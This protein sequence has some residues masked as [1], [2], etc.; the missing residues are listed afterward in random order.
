LSLR[1]RSLADDRINT[2]K[3]ERVTAVKEVKMKGAASKIL[4][5][6]GIMLILAAILWWA[7]AVNSLVKLPDDVELGFQ[8]EGEIT[9]YQ[10]SLTQERFPEGEEKKASLQTEMAC[11]ANASEFSSSTGVLEAV[12]TTRIEGMPEKRME[13]AYVLDRKTVENIKDDR[14]YAY[15]Y[16]DDEGNK[17]EGTVVNREDNYYPLLPLDTSKDQAYLFWKEEVASGFNLDYLDEEEKEGVTVFDYSGSFADMTVSEDYIRFM[18][19]PVEKTGEQVKS[20]LGSMG[21]DADN[22]L[23]SA[24]Q[25]MSPED[26][27]VV[28]QALEGSFPLE[29]LWTQEME[30]SVEPKSG[31]V[32]DIYKDTETLSARTQLD[33][34]TEAADIASKYAQDAEIGDVMTKL[35]GLRAAVEA[36]PPEKVFEYNVEQTDQSVKDGIEDAKNA[37]GSINLYKVYIPWALLIVGALILII[38]LL[39]GGGEA[40]M[41]ED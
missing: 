28:Q 19:L 3:S 40:P 29:Y 39:I 25:R 31:R 2:W 21:I 18:E 11:K 32:V 8:C 36:M 22:L 34:L 16:T 20:A 26:F 37:F 35:Q 15:G 14:A 4:I 7:I 5:A 24:S 6:L 33:R 17:H 30:V 12:F 41:Q 38:G 13:A 10:D 9:W 23:A 27:Q 1:R